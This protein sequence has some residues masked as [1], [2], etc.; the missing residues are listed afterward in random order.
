[1]RKDKETSF[2]D[3]V[4]LVRAN[5]SATPFF[6]ELERQRIP[7]EFLA[8]KGLYSQPVIL[9]I[10]SYF[11]LLDNYHESSAL[12]RLLSLP[13][14]E[15]GIEELVKIN[16]FSK[17]KTQSTYE[18][19]Q[20]LPLVSGISKNTV[21][22][23]GFLMDL[24][25]KHSKL[26]REKS[27]GDV[28][29]AFLNDSGYLKEMVKQESERDINLITQFY[30]KIK[31]FEESNPEPTLANFMMAMNMEL[32]SGEAGSLEMDIEKGPDAVKIMTIHSAKG[33]EFKFV[34]IINLVDRRFP[35]NERKEAIEIPCK[36]VKEIVPSGDV[37][38]QEERR[39]FYV[40]MTRAKKGLFFTSADDYGGARK[41][42]LSRFLEE[43]N[44]KKP[45]EQTGEKVSLESGQVETKEKRRTKYNI[46]PHFSYSQFA[47]FDKC[48]LQYKFSHILKIPR[49]GTAFFSFGKTIHNTLRQF[50]GD[51]L[52]NKEE[53]Q[54]GLFKNSAQPSAKKEIDF[55]EQFKK[56]IV[57]Y[58]RNWI[59]EWYEDKKQKQEYFKLGKDTL[60]DFLEKFLKEQPKILSLNSKPCLELDFF[61]KIKDNSIKGKI[62]RVDE[63]PDGELEIIDYKTG[64]GKDKLT[65]DEKEQLLIY[66]LAGEQIFGKMPEY[67]SYYYLQ[68]N[69]KITFQSNEREREKFKQE[70]LCKIEKIE[71]SDFKAA[72]GWQ[73][74]SCDFKNI[75]EFRKSG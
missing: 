20:D 5:D 24:I 50:L 36:L 43:I 33:L 31:S 27:I 19:L 32:E 17:K 23:I 14:F 30:K 66:Q 37:H 68:N 25:K 2:S 47:A 9:D 16:Q 35:T 28:F 49:I 18:T 6:K 74:Q 59:D 63:L 39:L 7:Y 12:N 72:P 65:K 52:E 62:D 58:E 51:Y 46:P 75:C 48:P 73:C 71:N 10:V 1:M 42:K 41:K 11:R 44:F 55:S 21:Q 45:E 57:F 38:L 54:E 3:F 56:M 40:A 22:K 60:K 4:V 13:L 69:E 70:V 26:I 34:F 67:L 8:S 64:K 29:L 61:L 53:N 15:V